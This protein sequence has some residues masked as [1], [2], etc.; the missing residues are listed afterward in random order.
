M[1]QKRV[2]EVMQSRFKITETGKDIHYQMNYT[3]VEDRQWEPETFTLLLTVSMVEKLVFA[4]YE[5][6][7]QFDTELVQNRALADQ[8]KE[9]LTRS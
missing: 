9:K 7:L 5:T 8:V 3:G 4:D 2:K 6:R 1:E